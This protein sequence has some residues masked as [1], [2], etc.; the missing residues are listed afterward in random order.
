MI[1]CRFSF[2]DYYRCTGILHA[3]PADSTLDCSRRQERSRSF[4]CLTGAQSDPRKNWDEVS[5]PPPPPPTPRGGHHSSRP[6]SPPPTPASGTRRRALPPATMPDPPASEAGRA[7]RRRHGPPAAPFY[8]HDLV[9]RPDCGPR[10]A[11]GPCR[12]GPGRKRARVRYRASARSP[13]CVGASAGALSAVAGRSP[14][15]RRAAAA[16]AAHPPLPR[17]CRSR[18]AR[19][20]RQWPSD[21]L[22][23]GYPPG[24]PGRGW[25][26]GL[27]EPRRV[28]G[29]SDSRLATRLK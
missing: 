16:G 24:L 13:L 3:Q 15:E 25:R 1:H 7:V 23:L 11:R 14:N 18:P 19:R 8:M 4:G 22:G 28:A 9:T 29:P 5:S 27:A 6:A 17:L 26:T 20:V 21:G 2:L 10:P 12:S